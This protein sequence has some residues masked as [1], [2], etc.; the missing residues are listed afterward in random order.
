MDNL[1]LK[2]GERLRLK[3]DAKNSEYRW[4]S[5]EPYGMVEVNWV[6]ME[7]V[8]LDQFMIEYFTTEE[9]KVVL[10]KQIKDKKAELEEL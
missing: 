7:E 5:Q 1:D 3:S 4:F 2:Y 10:K 8:G 9:T 6:L